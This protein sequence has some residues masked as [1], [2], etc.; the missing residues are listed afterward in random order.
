M[1]EVG[2]CAH[3]N[4]TYTDTPGPN[5]T[6]IVVVTCTTCSAPLGSYEKR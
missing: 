2:P 3:N 6:I 4:R 5:G 1:P